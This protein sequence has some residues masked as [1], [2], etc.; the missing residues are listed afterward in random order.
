[1]LKK[2][3]ILKNKNPF[4]RV[5]Y[6]H[7]RE[8]IGVIVVFFLVFLSLSLIS[9]N[10]FDNSWL[11]FSNKNGEISNWCGPL[12]SNVSTTFFYL[13]GI[14]SYLVLALFTYLSIIFL[15]KFSF[16]R[17]LD[18]LISFSF[19]TLISTTLLKL[20]DLNLLSNEPGGL[21][22]C[23][24]ANYLVG[25]IGKIGALVA[26]YSMLWICV[27][28]S[29]RVSLVNSVVATSKI[30]FSTIMKLLNIVWSALCF[31]FRKMGRIL[32]VL[33]N[34][35]SK[36]KNEDLFISKV[37]VISGKPEFTLDDST[38]SEE[39]INL[40]NLS[41]LTKKHVD[42]KAI[43][44]LYV[45]NF[46]GIEI[47]GLRNSVFAKNPFSLADSI[48]ELYKKQRSDS[49]LN[50]SLPDLSIFKSKKKN[51]E[52][53][54]LEKECKERAKKLEEKLCHF[55]IEGVVTAVLPGPVVTLFEYTPEMGTKISKIISLGDDLAMV[56]KALSIRIIAP[57]P[58]R[59]VVGF[60]ISNKNRKNVF[61]SDILLNKHFKSKNDT[62]PLALGVDIVGR[63]VIEDLLDMPHLLIAGSTGSGKSVGLNAMLVSLLCKLTP[64]EMKLILIDPK[65]LEFASYRDIPHLLFP[66]ITDPRKVP[67]VL[68]WVVREMEHRYEVMAEV[69][70]RN[71][72]DYRECF[73]ES[74]NKDLEELPFIVLIIDELA[75]LMMVAG[76]EVEIYITRIAQMARAAGIHMII[77][78]QRPSVDVLTGLIKVNFPS[79]VSFKVSSKV[80][81]KTILDS[82]GAEKLLGKGDMLC[83]DPRSSEL[84]RV[85]GAFVSDGEIN[86]LTKQLKSQQKP[87]YLD[88]EEMI[89]QEE[90]SKSEDC[91]DNLYS[92]V[93]E[94]VKTLDEVSISMLQRRYRIGF[95]RSARLIEALEMSGIVAPAQ[96]GKPR[97]VIR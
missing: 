78:T 96:G 58:G 90:T 94:F 91:D 6:R 3:K 34:R 27:V 77:A 38:E 69:G 83:S 5:L 80:D 28:I 52:T 53:E 62:L 88:L 73:K 65:R 43:H 37:P 44:E 23:C 97:K 70:V 95:N 47:F 92:E 49:N 71:L 32:L 72:L 12:G 40:D 75:D 76:K 74:A 89:F 45:Q 17:N 42:R 7:Q 9:F 2:S 25:A 4:L 19:I 64:S 50:Y 85:H 22:G 55:G 18:R 63:P 29:L 82:I 33:K 66:I 61:L 24:L 36:N 39:E 57:I 30:L 16:K 11:Y 15:F 35:F 67:I 87:D 54:V 79:R 31:I 26:L 14:S 10:P 81:S 13:F 46:L 51:E 1:M 41:S 56:L 48:I 93:I 84:R 86:Q 8:I 60:E 21:I 59:N 20:H 68:K